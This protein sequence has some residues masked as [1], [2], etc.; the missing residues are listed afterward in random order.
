MLH[1]SLFPFLLLDKQL[2]LKMR[3]VWMEIKPLNLDGNRFSFYS[4][5][6]HTCLS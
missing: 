5:Y 1:F 4:F 6:F 2:G 3:G